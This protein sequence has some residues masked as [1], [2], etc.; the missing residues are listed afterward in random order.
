MGI[1]YNP[2]LDRL[3]AIAVLAVIEYHA[4]W[5]W[6]GLDGVLGV[7]VFFVLSGFLI[8]SILLREQATGGIRLGA[9]YLRRARRLY[10]A[11][12]V[13]VVA[14]LLAGWA[15]PVAGLHAL[16]YVT[17]YV[18][19]SDILG[20]TWS[21]SVE[22]HYYLLW[23]LLLP[24]VARMPRQ[25]AVWLLCALY[26]GASLW[27]ALQPFEWRAGVRFDTRMTGLL[28]GALLAFLPR[29]TKLPFV[30]LAAACVLQFAGYSNHRPFAEA[31]TACVIVL[32]YRTTVPFL[33]RAPLVYLGRISYGMYLYHWPITWALR[34]VSEGLPQLLLIV[35]ATVACAAVS[36]HTIERWVRA[37]HDERNPQPAGRSSVAPRAKNSSRET[38]A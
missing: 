27:T 5:H 23:P 3:R 6:L 9:F 35:A 10:P 11:L 17:D 19:P 14:T 24:F 13:L 4:N 30:A 18:R 29:D 36:F 8:T 7:D 15:S 37:G 32:S 21:L 1:R 25:R 12:I 16:I 20:H 22:E 34:D 31:A 33:S 26:V 2:A 28:L 38:H